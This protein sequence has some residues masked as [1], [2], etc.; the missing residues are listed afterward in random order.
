MSRTDAPAGRGRILRYVGWSI[1]LVF[2]ASFVGLLAFGL[3]T[4]AADTTIDDALAK[5][6]PAQ[7]PGFKLE[8]LTGGTPPP[9]LAPLLT[10]A[11]SD[12]TIDLDE[13]R[14]TPVVLNFWASW[15]TPCREEAPLLQR[16][17]TKYG[18]DGVVFLGQNMQDTPGDAREFIAAFKQTFPTVRDPTNETARAWGAIGIPETYFIRRDGRVVGHI[19]GVVTSAQLGRGIADAQVGQ[20]AKPRVGGEQRPAR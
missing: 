18:P 4:R 10:R 8:V 15:C 5:A 6:Q 19:V 2:A 9:A 3:L 14:G 17:W 7:S 16:A 20:A 1:G 12:G 13:L 11:T